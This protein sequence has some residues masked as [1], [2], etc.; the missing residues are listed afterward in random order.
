MYAAENLILYIFIPICIYLVYLY[1]NPV[2]RKCQFCEKDGYFHKCEPNTGIQGEWCKKY[3]EADNLFLSIGKQIILLL[4]NVVEIAIFVPMVY[5]RSLPI[6]REL[7]VRISNFR[8]GKGVMLEVLNIMRIKSCGTKIFGK[9]I[10]ICHLINR[11]FDGL[12]ITINNSITTFSDKLISE[13]FDQISIGF[14]KIFSV[15]FKGFKHLFRVVKLLFEII[16]HSF[17]QII[18]RIQNIFSIISDLHFFTVFKS[19]SII[20]IGI[21]APGIIA[22]MLIA[23][24]SMFFIFAIPLGGIYGAYQFVIYTILTIINII[25]N[26]FDIDIH[27]SKIIRFLE[28]V[29]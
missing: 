16:I 12:K 20:V 22:S 27:E 6:A 4:K 29:F 25:Y 18:E 21:L 14:K 3:Y 17:E 7:L 11:V 13:I 10:D 5:I 28:A 2:I 8:P 19:I 15:I 9:N 24:S 26:I 23:F 1:S